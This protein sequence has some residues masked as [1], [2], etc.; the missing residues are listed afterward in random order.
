[1]KKSLLLLFIPFWMC[2]QG[3]NNEE[4]TLKNGDIDIPGTLTYPTTN[5]AIPLLI[6]IH[7]SGNVDRDGNQ[8]GKPSKANYIKTL[9]DSINSRGI[10]FFRYDKRTATASNLAK[11]PKTLV[12]DFATDATVVIDLF[13]QDARFSSVNLIGH[14]QG[15]LVA[16]LAIDDSISKFVSLAG[17]GQTID[18]SIV[19]QLERQNAD[20]A[21]GAKDY[22][23][24]LRE[25]DTIVDVNPFLRSIFAPKN[26]AFLK[27]W[28]QL[29]P[30]KKIAEISIPVLILNGDADIQVTLKDAQNL[31]QGLPTAQLQIIPKMNHV[32]KEVNSMTENMQSYSDESFPLSRTLVD[33]I[34]TFIKS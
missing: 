10:A 31:K 20:F 11:A 8:V 19:S 23:Q 5:E 15:S 3:I 13:K 21:K 17:P 18:R 27:Q 2:S 28:M 22:F 12:T 4:V 30:S 16:M 29:D 26:Q 1:M 33:A 25:T 6:F 34:S 7:G 32:L 24:E 9:A 14:S